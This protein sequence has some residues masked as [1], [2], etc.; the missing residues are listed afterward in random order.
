M[1]GISGFPDLNRNK[2]E[3]FLKRFSRPLT[4]RSRN[5]KRIRLNQEGKPFTVYAK[6]GMTR[7]CLPTLVKTVVR[8]MNETLGGRISELVRHVMNQTTAAMPMPSP[9]TGR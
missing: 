6:H 5:N 3:R 4:L 8:D 1:G 7:K 2:S 9:V